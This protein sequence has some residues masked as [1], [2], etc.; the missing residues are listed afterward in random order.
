MNL[1]AK[2]E[3]APVLERPMNLV[4]RVPVEVAP[5]LP[6]T[7]LQLGDI[8]IKHG[9]QE[10]LVSLN[11]MKSGHAF[12]AY[13]VENVNSAFEDLLREGIVKIQ[14][15]AAVLR[16]PHGQGMLKDPWL[17][18]NTATWEKSTVEEYGSHAARFEGKNIQVAPHAFAKE[19]IDWIQQLP[20]KIAL[21]DVQADLVVAHPAESKD[22]IEYKCYKAHEALLNRTQMDAHNLIE[23]ERELERNYQLERFNQALKAKNRAIFH[24]FEQILVCQEESQLQQTA[25][26]QRGLVA[27]QAQQQKTID[28]FVQANEA[29]QATLNKVKSH[30]DDAYIEMNRQQ[31]QIYSLC[32]QLQSCQAQLNGMSKQGS[33]SIL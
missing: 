3:L 30:L 24:R 2:G 11:L 31:A 23:Y 19:V 6:A 32:S 4:F 12:M 7:I 27:L 20:V 1:V 28:H 14:A 21:R 5:A 26:L 29:N 17:V 22:L 9:L 13:V 16:N 33:C 15:I 10:D 18:D 25:E 8:L